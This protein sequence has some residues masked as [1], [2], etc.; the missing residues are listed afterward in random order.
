MKENVGLKRIWTIKRYDDNRCYLDNRPYNITH[1]EGNKILNEGADTIWTL[2]CAGTGTKFDATNAYLGVGDSS[3][4]EAYDQTGL[5][6]V[7]NKYYKGMYSGYPKY[8]SS[9]KAIFQS[10]FIGTEANFNWNEFTIANGSSD[11]SMNLNRMVSAQ[12]TKT[13]GQIWELTLEL[14]FT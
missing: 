8:G 11:A 13:V 10:V 7:T 1:F 2:V 6:A 14:Q 3:I 5:Q 4:V 12:G 9:R